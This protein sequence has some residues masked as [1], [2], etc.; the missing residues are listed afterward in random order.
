MS[1]FDQSATVTIADIE[2][3]LVGIMGEISGTD[4]NDAIYSSLNSLWKNELKPKKSKNPE[5]TTNIQW[6]GKAYD[7]WESEANCPLSDGK[8]IV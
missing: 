8:I 7:Y 3:M 1:A 4:S 6:Y 2:S 5:N